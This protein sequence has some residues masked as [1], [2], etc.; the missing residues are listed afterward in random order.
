MNQG[1]VVPGLTNNRLERDSEPECSGMRAHLRSA[2]PLHLTAAILAIVSPNQGCIGPKTIMPITKV[3]DQKPSD[4]V[5]AQI[6]FASHGAAGILDLG[7]SKNC[8]WQ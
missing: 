2:L 4:H 5:E 7:A 1:K 8:N 3:S 6:C